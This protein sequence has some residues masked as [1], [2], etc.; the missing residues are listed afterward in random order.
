MKIYTR[1]IF[2]MN[3]SVQR[4][5]PSKD[6]Y[7]GEWSLWKEDF[8][9][10]IF[11]MLPLWARGFGVFNQPSRDLVNKHGDV[12][13]VPEGSALSSV[14]MLIPTTYQQ[15]WS[16]KYP[17]KFRLSARKPKQ[18]HA[19]EIHSKPPDQPTTRMIPLYNMLPSWDCESAI[20][21]PG[22]SI[23]S[24]PSAVPFVETTEARAAVDADGCCRLR[25]LGPLD[26]H[27]NKPKFD[28]DMNIRVRGSP[29]NRFPYE[30]LVH[31]VTL[32]LCAAKL[33]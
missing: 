13:V 18:F 19:I 14:Q 1:D 12:I 27:G 4:L 23:E 7:F 11:A 15:G 28:A 24:V 17:P 5:S 20:W 29:P 21:P 33:L 6:V 26:S 3:K 31:P 8:F 9:W 22:E 10:F 32:D 16:S 25:G 2:R 30:G